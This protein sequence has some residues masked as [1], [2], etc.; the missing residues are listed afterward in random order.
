MKRNVSSLLCCASNV[1]RCSE[2]R[3]YGTSLPFGDE[4]YANTANQV[5]R[6]AGK[7]DALAATPCPLWHVR[8]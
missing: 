3:Y 4:T 6:F 7:C 5:R 1:I 2:H 8:I